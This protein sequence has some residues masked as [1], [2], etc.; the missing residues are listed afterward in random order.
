MKVGFLNF[1]PRSKRAIYFFMTGALPQIDLWDYEPNLAAHFEKD[2]PDSDC[3]NQQL[4]HMTAVSRLLWRTDHS[5]LRSVWNRA[6]V[7]G[8]TRAYQPKLLA[9]DP[10]STTTPLHQIPLIRAHRSQLSREF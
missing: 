3:G 4:I 6:R 7:A 2:L 9:E 10:A 1:A 5:I 8:A